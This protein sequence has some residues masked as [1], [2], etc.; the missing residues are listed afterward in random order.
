M[1]P[2][3]R[4]SLVFVACSALASAL[5]TGTAN[6]TDATR[7]TCLG[8]V[9]TIV[10][11]TDSVQGTTGDD[12]IVLTRPAKV[13]AGAGNDTV[14]GS[15]GADVIN[16]GGG[17]DT[18]DG[19]SGNDRVNGG[20]GDDTVFGGPGADVVIGGDGADHLFGDTGDDTMAATPS[21]HV[22]PGPGD[23][24]VES[25]GR[26]NAF[27]PSEGAGF[28]IHMSAADAA[29]LRATGKQLVLAVGDPG[30]TNALVMTSQQIDSVMEFVF[31]PTVYGVFQTAD[32]DRP[33]RRGVELRPGQLLTW[34]PGRSTEVRSLSSDQAALGAY[35]LRTFNAPGAMGLNIVLE[36][37]TS[38]F[39]VPV[40]SFDLVDRGFERIL[41]LP[42][43]VSIFLSE[44]V[45]SGSRV[46]IPQQARRIQL[47]PGDDSGY[48]YQDDE[49]LR[50]R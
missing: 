35:G 1:P 10:G 30:D 26:I 46:A 39:T 27:L 48:I 43:A 37:S 28:S 21:D 22:V 3:V 6:A 14:C 5:F 7:P 12:V 18:I 45:A 49:L 23:D 42:E 19:R 16:G 20:I 34:L 2:L 17:D 8:K 15:S 38:R 50:V 32:A 4:T 13:S 47:K 29:A 11:T 33:V 24:T 40:Y 41:N 9:A 31:R 25:R 44:P 36:T